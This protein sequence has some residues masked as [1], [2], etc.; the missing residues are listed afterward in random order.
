MSKVISCEIFGKYMTALHYSDS[1]WQ[2]FLEQ[3]DLLDFE[4]IWSREDEWFEEPNHRSFKNGWSGVARIEIDRRVLY[5]KKQSNYITFSP[6]YPLG[7]TLARR[8]FE[9]IQMFNEN[10]IPSLKVVGSGCRKVKNELQAIILTEG[11]EEYKSLYEMMVFLKTNDLP[12]QIKRSF[13]EDVANL[14]H[15]AHVQNI[16]HNN[17]YPKHIFIA[18]EYFQGR[19]PKD[20]PGSRFIDLEGAKKALILDRRARDLATLNRRSNFWSRTQRLF[21][22]LKYLG[23]SRVDTEVRQFIKTLTKRRKK[24]IAK[25]LKKLLLQ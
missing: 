24:K 16:L 13:I 11:L 20:K 8:E 18:N 15:K 3:N 17:L 14:I 12:F 7:T 9:N 19:L 5:L 4:S 23:K 6:K 22:L 25:V 21:F 1:K 2:T 10:G